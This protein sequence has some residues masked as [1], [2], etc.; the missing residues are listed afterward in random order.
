M[1]NLLLCYTPYLI[2]HALT[3]VAMPKGMLILPGFQT[4]SH[5]FLQDW[6]KPNK[7]VTNKGVPKDMLSHAQSPLLPDD[8]FSARLAIDSS[9]SSIFGHPISARSHLANDT[10]TDLLQQSLY[11]HTANKAQY[12]V[13]PGQY[14]CSTGHC[15]LYSATAPAS[16]MPESDMY[17]RT[18]QLLDMPAPAHNALH[19]D[20]INSPT[21][22]LPDGTQRPCMPKY[23]HDTSFNTY[24]IG[25]KGLSSRRMSNPHEISAEALTSTWSGQHLETGCTSTG[26]SNFAT[27]LQAGVQPVCQQ[28]LCCYK[29]ETQCLCMIMKALYLS[30][31]LIM[32]HD[33]LL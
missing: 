32:L 10:A 27:R 5:A 21:A 9:P 20:I 1:Q 28:L 3:L 24:S 13:E 16:S 30:L 11:M 33:C 19:K 15:S 14:Y 17:S 2:V 8:H 29:T 12:H 4:L 18:R 25:N 22:L 7:H 6:T 31:A 23:T 26:H